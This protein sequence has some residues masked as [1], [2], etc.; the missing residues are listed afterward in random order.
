MINN[1]L[2]KSGIV[3]VII[4]FISLSIIP[5]TG[6]I[7]EKSALPVSF[8]N[9]ILYVG[10]SGPNNYTRIQD[11]I[12]NASDG[13]TIFVF[14][15]KYYGGLIVEKSLILIGENKEST[16]I[17]GTEGPGH[18]GIS[19]YGDGVLL[20]GFTIHNVGGFWPD[21]AIYI[22]SYDNIICNNIIKNNKLGIDMLESL[23]NIISQN[24][25]E[26]QQYY[27]VNMRY[28]SNNNISSNIIFNNK[29]TGINI[30]GSYDNTIIENTILNN[31]W[32]GLAIL[33]RTVTN[34][35]IYHN[36]FFNND[37]DNG[38]DSGLNVWDNDYPSGGNYW[39][40]YEG[41]DDDGDGI[42]DTPYVIPGGD[43]EDNYPLMKPYGIPETKLEM[44]IKGGIGVT[45]F[46]TN[47]GSTDA[48]D[49]EWHVE[50]TGGIFGRINLRTK[51]T[52]NILPSN[53]IIVEKMP[54]AVG[55]G[56]LEIAATASA[57]N[58]ETF[59]E[60]KKGFM[61]LFFVLLK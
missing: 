6:T 61:L 34:N 46:I 28:S 31:N 4:L 36:N 35:F 19:I 57:A 8:C 48:F 45:L 58:S 3:A 40:D 11:A 42:G 38:F 32:S 52:F 33:D 16:F 53:E 51:G 50:I 20:T 25:I 43:N 26:N 15:G 29:R 17:D 59:S 5:L 2:K 7:L 21:S 44:E 22:N 30:F 47:V 9:D 39:D 18:N 41:V 54:S 10:G 37:P 13:D 14:S 49:G 12:D 23:N 1:L 56:P 27:G 24:I 60:T 55:F